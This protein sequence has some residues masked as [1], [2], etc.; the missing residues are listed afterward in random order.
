MKY[1][2]DDK[3]IIIF[4]LVFDCAHNIIPMG[5]LY[6]SIEYFL[7]IREQNPDVQLLFYIIPTSKLFFQSLDK[8]KQHVG[9]SYVDFSIPAITL[10][11]IKDQLRNIIDGKYLIDDYS[12]MD[13]IHLIELTKL[14]L[15]NN[16]NKILTLDLSTPRKFKMF[17][18]RAQTEVLI[19]PEWTKNEY[20]YQSKINNVNYYTEMPFCKCD[21]PYKMKFAFKRLR[22]I[23][24]ELP[25]KLYINYPQMSFPFTDPQINGIINNYNKEVL[26]KEGNFFFD[27]HERFNEYI[28]FQSVKWFDPHPKL[29]HECKFYGK[30]YHYYNLNNVKDGSYYRYRDSLTE[31]ISERELTKDDVIVQKMSS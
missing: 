9:N 2:F 18:A 17:L 26:I 13:N 30:P 5:S 6:D 19:V 23:P 31:S 27:L 8:N 15:R 28:Y 12:F 25:N 14:F 20:Y 24:K 7:E 21:V 16:P 11:T 3:N 10:L 4:G 1:N 22:S 29:F